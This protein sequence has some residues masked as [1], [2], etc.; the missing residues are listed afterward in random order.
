M[1]KQRAAEL[2]A[3]IQMCDALSR[4]VPKLPA[5]VEILLANCLAHG[6]RQFVEVAANFP[7]EC[8]YVLEM[9]G[10]VYGHDAEAREQAL[11]PEQRL[12]FHQQRSGPVMEQ[13]HHWLEAQLAEERRSRT[14]GSAR[15]SR[16]CCGTGGP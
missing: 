6:R 5:G 3:P 13:L 9:L 14:P 10:Q 4:N 11:T 15:R 16:T 7:D 12:Q 2:P 8:R 1:L